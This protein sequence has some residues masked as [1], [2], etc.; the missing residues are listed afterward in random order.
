MGDILYSSSPTPSSDGSWLGPPALLQY[1]IQ[2][3]LTSYVTYNVSILFFKQIK[4]LEAKYPDLA[5]L[6]KLCVQVGK[7][8]FLLRLM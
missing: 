4:E 8:F 5:K 3:L 7:M 2:L 1:H 6:A